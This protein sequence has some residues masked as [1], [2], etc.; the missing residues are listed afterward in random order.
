LRHTAANLGHRSPTPIPARSSPA[1]TPAAEL[2]HLPTDSPPPGPSSQ[3]EPPLGSP[4]PPCARAPA[5]YP[6]TGSP[7]ANR[8]RAHQR[9][10]AAEPVGG[11]V[12]PRGRPVHPAVDRWRR[13]PPL[14]LSLACGPRGDAVPLAR[15]RCLPPWAAAGPTQPRVRARP[16]PGWARSPHG[17][18]EA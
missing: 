6:R 3:I 1:A 17:P 9:R 13:P 10:I 8:R 12:L 16:A 14:S 15:S 5:H 2:R 4:A 7:T 11:R 18:P